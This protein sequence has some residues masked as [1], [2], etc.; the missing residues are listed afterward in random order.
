M[1]MRRFLVST[2]V[3]QFTG[4]DLMWFDAPRY[5]MS[6]EISVSDVE[7]DAEI[8]EDADDTEA[9][10]EEIPAA[11]DWRDIHRRAVEAMRRDEEQ[12][13]NTEIPDGDSSGQS[14]IERSHHMQMAECAGDFC[15]AVQ[16]YLDFVTRFVEREDASDKEIKERISACKNHIA[17]AFKAMKLNVEDRLDEF[18]KK[19]ILTWKKYIRTAVMMRERADAEDVTL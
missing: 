13:R 12:R 5:M 6:D 19:P 17:T 9:N 16:A 18:L 1:V 3:G 15:R 7:D 2:G 11:R 8:G 4:K 10:N 14:R